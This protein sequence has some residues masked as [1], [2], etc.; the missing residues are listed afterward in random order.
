MNRVVLYLVLI[1]VVLHTDFWF[2]SSSETV[3]G[4]PIGLTYHIGLSIVTSV[5]WAGVCFF[6]WPKELEGY[7]DDVSK[8]KPPKEGN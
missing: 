7:D 1:L 5:V 6:A 8:G 2:W 4:M 3:L